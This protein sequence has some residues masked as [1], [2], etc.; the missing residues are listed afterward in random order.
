MNQAMSSLDYLSSLSSMLSE[1]LS[2]TRVEGLPAEITEAVKLAQMEMQGVP[3]ALENLE[4]ARQGF[5]RLDQ[6]IDRLLILAQEASELG[7]EDRKGRAVRQEEF[8]RLTQIVARLA[9][10]RDYHQ[11]KLS[12]LSRPQA[13]AAKM[14]L[15]CLVP[16]KNDLASQ[17]KEQE[18]NIIQA[19][20]ATLEFINAVK[21]AFPMAMA[22]V[23]AFSWSAISPGTPRQTMHTGL[24]HGS[25]LH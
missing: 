16:V 10:R 22:E 13:R 21:K 19:V 8:M 2:G 9:G 11:P 15:Q 23:P 20:E 14:A 17:L 25:A 3:D 5:D 6:A 7:D 18:N 1:G 24:S 4:R 12:L